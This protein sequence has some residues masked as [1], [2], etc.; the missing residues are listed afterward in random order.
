MKSKSVSR[1]A[2]T[3]FVRITIPS[4][5]PAGAATTDGDSSERIGKMERTQLFRRQNKDCL[6]IHFINAEKLKA[7]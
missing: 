4:N 6:G 3:P 7:P 5:T 1:S 2:L